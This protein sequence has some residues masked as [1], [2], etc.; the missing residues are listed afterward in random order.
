MTGYPNRVAAAAI[1]LGLGT[2]LGAQG[3]AKLREDAKK[4]FG[5]VQAVP[6]ATLA[7][8]EVTL[9]RAL[10]WDARLSGDGKTACASCHHLA[11][12]GADRRQFSPDAKGKQTARNSQT[13]FN[14][15]LQPNLR[16]I[17]DRKSGAHQAEKS[18]TG[19]MGLASAEAVIPLLKTAGYEAAFKAAYPKDAEPLSPAN[20]G[21]AIEAY[22]ATLTTPAPFDR[23][24]AGEDGALNAQQKAGLQVFVKSGC[25]DCHRGALLGGGSLKKFGVAKDYWTAT[26]SEKKDAG[27]FEATKNEAD[28]YKFRVSMLRNIAKTAPY[29]HDGSVADLTEAVQVMADVQLGNRLGAADAAA[30]VAFLEA[31]TGEAP[32]HYGPPATK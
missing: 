14:A 28:Q 13:V 23:F 22:E 6:D 5:V 27:L 2:V 7:Q 3:D 9:G 20:Y 19:S 8:P 30:I 4:V 21:K 24:L 31:L 12:W 26:K 29:F 32:K 16:W 17:G 25:T 15:T 10:F 1:V 18:L 11:D